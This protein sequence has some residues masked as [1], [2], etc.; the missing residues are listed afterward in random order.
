MQIWMKVIG[1]FLV[2]RALLGL[3]FGIAPLI[4]RRFSDIQKKSGDN[5]GKR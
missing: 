5:T 1:L 3:W 2:G 4:E